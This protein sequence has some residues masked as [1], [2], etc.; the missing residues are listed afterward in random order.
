[1]KRIASVLIVFAMLSQACS[2]PQQAVLPDHRI[3]H[4]VARETTVQV[5]VRRADGQ[6][7]AERV[8][9]M[10]GW[11]VASPQVVEPRAPPD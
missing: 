5:W 7:V 10:P 1:M 4:Q 9:L 6:L 11:W 2:L 3:P 8:R